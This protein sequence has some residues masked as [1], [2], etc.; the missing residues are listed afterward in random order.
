M[1]A[2]L[3]TCD[4]WVM[5]VKG[6]GLLR[7]CAE[8]V[9]VWQGVPVGTWGQKCEGGFVS[10]RGGYTQECLS[11]VCEG[12][13]GSGSGCERVLW[14]LRHCAWKASGVQCACAWPPA[15]TRAGPCVVR[16]WCGAHHPGFRPPR[17]PPPP[18]PGPGSSWVS[19][20]AFVPPFTPPPAFLMGEELGEFLSN[21]NSSSACLVGEHFPNPL[22]T[23]DCQALSSSSQWGPAYWVT[24]AQNSPAAVQRGQ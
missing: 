8:G 19:Q 2:Y 10:T 17:P 14:P 6:E 12:G 16:T 15:H 23:P 21:P 24:G 13:C 9:G 22:G 11:F 3:C 1:C 20:T 7:I 4:L 5:C 18:G